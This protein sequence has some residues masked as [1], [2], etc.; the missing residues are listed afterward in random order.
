MSFPLV[1]DIT[2]MHIFRLNTFLWFNFA[3]A[4]RYLLDKYRRVSVFSEAK[5]VVHPVLYLLSDKADMI[6][7]VT[8]DVDGGFS[9]V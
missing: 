3:H 7:G 1:F 9:A 4:R 8:L 2:C 6:N 5:D